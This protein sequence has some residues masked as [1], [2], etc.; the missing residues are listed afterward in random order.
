MNRR[1][2]I[3]ATC[4]IVIAGILFALASATPPMGGWLRWLAGLGPSES[5]FQRDFDRELAAYRQ[6]EDPRSATAALL[7]WERVLAKYESAHTEHIQLSYHQLVL[8]GRLY[9]IYT[10]LGETNKTKQCH[11]QITRLLLKESSPGTRAD[12][13]DFQTF[14]DSIDRLDAD[15]GARWKQSK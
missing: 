5:D 12:G 9:R 3:I 4:V 15:T 1:A 14:Y 7:D 11:E 6:A 13:I 8:Y 10:E 2:I